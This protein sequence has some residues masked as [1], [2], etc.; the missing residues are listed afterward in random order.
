MPVQAPQEDIDKYMGNYDEAWTTL[1]QRRLERAT[2]LGVVPGDT[3]LAPVPSTAD[4]DSLTDEEK[5][6][7]SKEMAVYAAMIDA[8]DHH[9]GQLVQYLEDGVL[10]GVKVCVCSQKRITATRPTVR[11]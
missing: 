8:M 10:I 3:K 5:R 4:W 9:I 11:A 2:A 7:K 6:Y 1:R